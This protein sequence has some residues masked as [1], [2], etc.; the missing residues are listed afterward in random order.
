MRSAPG[1]AD[2]DPLQELIHPSAVWRTILAA[3]REG[4]L[5]VGREG[6]I[7][8][9]N[10]AAERIFPTPPTSSRPLRLID[11]T[12]D[13]A[14]HEGFQQVFERGT[15]VE[16]RL[17]VRR[18]E[19]RVF[20]VT[21]APLGFESDIPRAALGVFV[22][23]TALEH[24]E[25][26]RRDF[27]VNLSHELRTP[28][29]A[30]LAY[31]E[32]LRDAGP[33]VPEHVRTYLDGLFRQAQRLHALV[34]DITDL[35][36]IESGA[37]ALGP[38]EIWLHGFVEDVLALI[39]PQAER[40]G[41]LL[42]NEVAVDLRVWA[43]PDRLTQI[44][45]NLL[46]NAVKFTP[47]GG[48]VWVTAQQIGARVSVS[49]KDTGIGISPA[50]QPRIFE[51]FYRGEKSRSRETGGSGL[52]L[53]IVKHLVELHGGEITVRSKPGVG[54]EF[55]FTLKAAPTSSPEGIAEA[56]EGERQ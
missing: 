9:Q 46:D 5:I 37:I 49:V 48:R 13:P 12:R 43:D 32:T 29:A 24:L 34:R 31:V 47:P 55:T 2:R 54:S 25:R 39:A 50:D 38:E 11:L 40:R 23:I 14:L 10:P 45:Y 7:L 17:E 27:F 53:A 56:P 8:V 21:I 30:I 19:P 41:I 52:G 28:L 44:L 36:E 33:D 22:E 18:G 26:V 3:M 15:S 4:L 35:M 51:R 42:S 16:L 20:Q 1:E 6:Q